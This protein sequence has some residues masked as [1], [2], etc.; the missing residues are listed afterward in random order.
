MVRFSVARR[1]LALVAVAATG[2]AACA[3]P[4]IP[5]V[6]APA[7]S[8]PI[9]EPTPTPA[10]TVEDAPTATPAPFESEPGVTADQIRLGVIIDVGGG[11]VSDRISASAAE[12][13]EAWALAV[14]GQ[15]GLAGREVV[16]ERI[17]TDPLLADHAEAI[18]RACNLDLFALVGSSAIFDDAGLDQ[19]QSPACGLPDF[20]ATVSTIERLE[21]EVTTAPNPIHS[22]MWSAGWARYYEET[23][24]RAVTR[25][26]T[27]LLDFPV[28]VVTGERMIEAATAQ[29]FEFVYRP[30][31]AFD[32]DFTAEV[33]ELADAGAA[34]LTWRN[35][36]DR[37]V[38]LLAQLA[39]QDV[40]LTVDCGQAC[41]APAW[42]E[43]A[44]PLGEGVEVWLPTLP[45]EDAAVAP[46][47]LRYLF[48]L[49][50]A[51]GQAEPTSAG[52]LAWSAAL[53]FEEA[54][55]T[56]IGAGTADYDPDSLTR[57]GVLAAADEITEWDGRGLH[58]V[59]NPAAGVPSPCFV[60]L[61]LR[62]GS[63][64]RTHP[65]R[66]GSL[67]CEPENLVALTATST[68]GAEEDPTPPPEAEEPTEE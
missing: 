59:A 53:L 35:D 24:P 30:E 66:R 40:E 31:I 52:I 67:D 33:S 64:E 46:E 61:T 65:D 44:G 7:T 51:H 54:V 56:A 36:G 21:S 62:N 58:G 15:G 60:N 2:A 45:V 32:T 4:A 16:V 6:I 63:W 68:L 41:Y 13:V 23:R 42:V 57:V 37:L 1:V 34:M 26:A 20:P 48:Q 43:L 8:T 28:T 19:L 38:E 12:A 49:G 50:A 17:P 29:G 11:P 5:E 39:E 9:P 27:M 47:L 18:D 3:S 22:T 55:N 25:A 14:N 10:P